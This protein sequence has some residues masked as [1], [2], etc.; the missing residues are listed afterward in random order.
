[1]DQT[2][3]K[4]YPQKRAV[5]A[6]AIVFIVDAEGVPVSGATVY[7]HWEDATT[8]SDS[9]VT[10]DIGGVF[11]RSDTVRNPPVGTTFTFVVDNVILSGWSYNPDFN[12]ET[13][14]SVS[15]P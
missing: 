8:D 13:R 9:G 5:L 15:Y 4:E 3:R 7:G 10:D 11:L 1:V 6:E 12:L 2:S 14:D